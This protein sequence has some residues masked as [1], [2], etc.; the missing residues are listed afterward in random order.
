MENP[1]F[2]HL[3]D[4]PF[5]GLS[6]VNPYQVPNSFDYGQWRD[7]A[8]IK[9]LSVPW[10][11]G[12]RNVV[13][14]PNDAERD[15]WL[16]SRDAYRVDEPTRVMVSPDGTVRVP[17]PFN[18]AS[19]ANYLVVDYPDMP[20]PGGSPARHRFCYFITSA[21]E[22]APSTTELA[23]ELDV[24]T[25]FSNSL[26]VSGL[27]LERGHAPMAAV[28]A[29]E[30]LAAPVR[31]CRYL[32]APDVTYGSI[33]VM[34]SRTSHVVNREVYAIVFMTGAPTED[35]GSY[36]TDDINVPVQPITYHN[37]VPSL[38]SFA[39]EPE[40]LMDFLTRMR[41]AAPQAFQTVGCVAF[42]PKSLTGYSDTIEVFG[43]EVYALWSRGWIENDL[44]DL[45]K[46]LF[47]YDSRYADMA[48]LY[49]YPYA[50]LRMRDHEGNT[51]PVRI[52][53]TA[54]T[55]SVFACIA[56]TFPVLK[57]DT[58]IGGIGKGV[59][60]SL[61][62][63]NASSATIDLDS[64]AFATLRSWGVPAFAV[65]LDPHTRATYAGYYD[66]VQARTALENAY[67][68]ALAS[69]DT[70]K[71]NADASATAGW[72]GTRTSVN[73]AEASINSALL[74]Q[75]DMFLNAAE[76]QAAGMAQ[77]MVQSAV[78]L[79]ASQTNSVISLA[80]SAGSQI[81]GAALAG[82]ATGSIV[83]GAGTA[84][85]AVA[86]V[87]AGILSTTM[88]GLT[89][90][91]VATNDTNAMRQSND[92][93]N[94]YLQA[95]YGGAFGAVDPSGFYELYNSFSGG[96]AAGIVGQAG[97][98]TRKQSNDQTLITEHATEANGRTARALVSGG[99]G[100]VVDTSGNL[101]ADE[102]FTGNAVRSKATADANAAR[103]RDTASSAIANTYRSQDL[104][105]PLQAG[106][107]SNGENAFTRPLAWFAEVFTQ[108][109]GAIE[110]AAHQFARYGYNLGQLWNVDKWQVMR[111]FTY[112]Q[113]S[114][115][116]VTPS[117]NG[118]TQGAADIVRDILIA[119]TTV[120]S[121]P[122]SIGAVDIWEN[123]LQ[124][125]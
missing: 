46:P 24:W 33:E 69:N 3:P 55:L 10:D 65:Y 35:W 99:T 108:P 26:S 123:H 100:Y 30:Y 36:A 83:P 107:Y 12:Y 72:L 37:G 76:Q 19:Q 102:V 106:T 50:E 82:A 81:G 86:G 41:S 118:A 77:S 15:D 42:V 103:S 91:A 61:T 32:T 16:N 111:F 80:G 115:V 73:A 101:S 13:E 11:S 5:P 34:T 125:R 25:T 44:V 113:A 89:N 21:S 85:G 43:V 71:A 27:M 52:E 97:V 116:W 121:D 58:Y 20:V 56:L 14:W 90:A 95:M 17:V 31:N 9:V 51:V 4:T 23:V 59:T 117:G 88:S 64:D 47:K 74:Y 114:D 49:T 57:I 45:A 75:S 8:R 2:P 40:K 67:S 87:G 93:S 22:V 105:A 54:G 48:K 1:R 124:R 39:M 53:D 79:N 98:M 104:M 94:A 112:W 18:V 7:N 92:S 63:A 60:S 78:N 96:S 109:L 110:A 122:A 66:R 119:G 120:W 38:P 68:S 84:A 6:N 29:S 70:A 62:F 28:S